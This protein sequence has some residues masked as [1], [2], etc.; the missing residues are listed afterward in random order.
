M[1]EETKSDNDVKV[2]DNAKEF[3]VKLGELTKEHNCRMIGQV[4][5]LDRTDEGNTI[6][7]GMIEGDYSPLEFRGTIEEFYDNM[8]RRVNNPLIGLMG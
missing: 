7:G 6:V 3:Q 2:G 4:E 1:V 5:F 8:K